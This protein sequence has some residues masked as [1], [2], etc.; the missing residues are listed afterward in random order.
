[1]LDF[2]KKHQSTIL[3]ISLVVGA[4]L[5]YSNSLRQQQHT[6]LFEQGILQLTNPFY[7]SINTASRSATESWDNYINLIGVQQQ[8]VELKE[9]LRHS[10]RQLLD[11]HEIAQE[12][13]RL[14]K[15]LNFKPNQQ[16]PEIPACVIA[17][18]ASNWFRTITIDKGTTDNL[19]EGL[20]VVVTEGIVG[21]TIKCSANTSRILLATD[22]ASEVAALIQH[23][24]TRGIV[25]GRGGKLTFDYALRKKDVQIGDM[26]VTA[27]TGG[28]FPKGIPIGIISNIIK[29][30]Y[31]LFQTLELTPCVDFSRLEDVL[32]IQQ[33][34]Q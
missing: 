13:I 15:L 25:R 1:M 2:L 26:V 33:N 17:V 10:K 6:T 32:V 8:N 27:G 16:F 20:P 22:A 24:R 28:I 18:D 12:N 4:L 19:Q 3:F 11:L 34:K 14:R 21:R 29:P 7:R 30:D 5:L 23:N 31:G 9:Q